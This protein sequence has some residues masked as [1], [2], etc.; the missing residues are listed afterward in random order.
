MPVEVAKPGIDIGIVSAEGEPLVAFYRDALGFS[1][2]DPLVMPG[3]GTIYRL[4]CGESLLRILQPETPPSG[5][6]ADGGLDG[7]PGYR[8][9]GLEVTDVR[10]SAD[11]VEAAGGSVVLGPLEPRP[12]RLVCQVRDP[13]GNLIELA[14]GG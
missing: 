10:A 8:Y 7:R 14:Q 13:D 5:N 4:Q 12:G 1:P 9:M 11:I 6:A 3:I 2:L